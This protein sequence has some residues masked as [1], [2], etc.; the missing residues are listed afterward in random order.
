MIT[1]YLSAEALIKQRLIAEVPAVNERNVLSARDLEGIQESAQPVPALHVLYFDDEVPGGDGDKA[2]HGRHQRI[3]QLWT[4]MVVVRNVRDATGQ[5][6]RQEAG[7][8]ILA[9]LKALQGWT[10]SPDHGP[11]QRRKAPFRTTYR[12]GFAYFPFLFSTQVLIQGNP[13]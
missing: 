1:N 8:L 3:Q 7:E 4:V 13:S 6:V 12:N 5:A 9:V 2:I 11:L 10:P